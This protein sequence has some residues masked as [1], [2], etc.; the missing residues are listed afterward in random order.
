M[1]CTI[2]A[3]GIIGP[4]IVEG[5]DGV[6]VTVNAERY[7]HMLENF[8]LPE[9][10]RRNWKMARAW[11]QQDGATGHT[12][13]ISM[14]TLG[15]T[16]PGRLLSRFGEIQWPSNS[17]DLTAADYFLWGYLK[18]QVYTHILPDIN[19]LKNAIRQESANVTQDTLRRVMASVTGRWQQCFEC[20]GG[21]LQDVVLKT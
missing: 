20:H 17:P 8:F 21:H 6:S 3:Q 19:S 11:F 5:V 2:S 10:R 14:N 4:C 9:M 1:W 12:A 13:R 7:N 16:F 15:A 18:A